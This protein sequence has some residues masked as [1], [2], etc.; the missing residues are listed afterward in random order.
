MTK[1]ELIRDLCSVEFRSKSKTRELVDTFIKEL[2][3][4]FRK[5]FE[6]EIKDHLTCGNDQC[7]HDGWCYHSTDI[8]FEKMVKFLE[9]M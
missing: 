2:A 1:E 3:Q 9:D 5:E 8:E 6:P 7:F 4:K